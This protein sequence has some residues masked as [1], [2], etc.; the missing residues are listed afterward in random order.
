MCQQWAYLGELGKVLALAPEAAR[1]ANEINH[2][3]W[4]SGMHY[5][6]G[7]NAFALMD[8]ASA[9]AELS[10][11]LAQALKLGSAMWIGFNGAYLALTHAARG[12]FAR[13]EQTIRTGYTPEY[14]PINLTE[15]LQQMAW[16]RILLA[17]GEPVAALGVVEELLASTP[18]SPALRAQ[19]IPQ[20]LL[21]RGKALAALRRV[22]EA[23][24]AL[25]EALRG[26]CMPGWGIMPKRRKSSRRRGRSLRD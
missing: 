16:G 11:G 22:E 4:I 20:L 12:D 24:Y 10:Q 5:V 7:R 26:G 1:L 19:P 17:R 2:P 18:G 13:A 25:S 14:V 6:R 15:R 21:L 3:Q 23:D 9:E 8:Y